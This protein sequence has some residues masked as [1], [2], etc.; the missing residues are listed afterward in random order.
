MFFISDL[1]LTL[2]RRMQ[3]MTI[4]F[5]KSWDK[6]YVLAVL[7]DFLDVTKVIPMVILAV[8][9]V[10]A[11]FG[12][13]ASSST[14]LKISAVAVIFAGIIV[15]PLQFV[16]EEINRLFWQASDEKYNSKA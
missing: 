11:L 8:A 7:S 10:A 6:V 9:F 5:V 12:L 16:A 3:S 15:I 4:P 1:S 13:I 14:A 2:S